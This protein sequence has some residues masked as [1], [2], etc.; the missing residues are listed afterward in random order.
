MD[1]ALAQWGP[2][3][4]AP[5]T[6]GRRRR[7]GF[8]SKFWDDD[9]TTT[10][11]AAAR[12][13]SLPVRRRASRT[14]RPLEPERISFPNS[15]PVGSIVIDTKGRQ[16]LLIQSSRP[17]RCATR[18]RSAAKA[19]T[20]PARNDQPQGRLARLASAGGDARA[21]PEPARED[22]RRRAET[23][24]AP[25]RS[26]SATTLYRIHGTNDAKSIGR[27]ASSGCFRMLNGHIV[28]LVQSRRTR[29]DG[30]RWCAVC[31]RSWKPSP[32]R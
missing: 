26:I 5:P 30:D 14:S 28:D 7:T 6:P 8:F 13:P 3:P 32:S 2:P 22:D 4:A 24:S 23:R 1:A 11:N 21:R 9:E 16:L 31:R 15:Y 27:R 20:G 17:R 12:G 19:S 25:W 10:M 29:H 18:S